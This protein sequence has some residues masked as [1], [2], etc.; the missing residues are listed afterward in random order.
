MWLLHSHPFWTRAFQQNVSYTSQAKLD[1]EM[2]TLEAQSETQSVYMC[3][4][5]LK[6]LKIHNITK[7]WFHHPTS[8]TLEKYRKLWLS[9]SPCNFVIKALCMVT[10]YVSFWQRV[11][12]VSWWAIFC[13]LVFP[14]FDSISTLSL[15]WEKSKNDKFYKN[16]WL[17]TNKSNIKL[18]FILSNKIKTKSTSYKRHFMSSNFQLC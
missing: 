12:L 18:E 6:P 10:T 3:V 5:L 8:S 11:P 2:H 17:W 14:W 15:W 13:L 9:C 7:A 16:Q 4:L 1:K